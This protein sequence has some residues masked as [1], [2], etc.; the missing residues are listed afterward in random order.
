[1]AFDEAVRWESPVQT[2]FRTGTADI[3]IG[4]TT[5]PDGRHHNNTSRAWDSLP[6]RVHRT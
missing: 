1:M 6:V 4:P 2:F 3:R 5:I